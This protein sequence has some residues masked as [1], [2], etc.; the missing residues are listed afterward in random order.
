MIR[1]DRDAWTSFPS[2]FLELAKG[3]FS[4]MDASDDAYTDMFRDEFPFTLD[5]AVGVPVEQ[6]QGEHKVSSH[7]LQPSRGWTLMFSDLSQR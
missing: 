3:L 1:S 5:P 6:S 4:R 2:A 7:P